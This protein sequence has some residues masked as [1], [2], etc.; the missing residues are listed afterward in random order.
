MKSLLYDEKCAR[1]R[2]KISAERNCQFRS[3]TNQIVTDKK[4]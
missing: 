4:K 3:H 1:V 2:M